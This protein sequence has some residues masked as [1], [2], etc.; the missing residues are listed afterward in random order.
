MSHVTPTVGI[1]VSSTTHTLFTATGTSILWDVSKVT[2][3]KLARDETGVLVKDTTELAFDGEEIEDI[4]TFDDDVFLLTRKPTGDEWSRPWKRRRNVAV[5]QDPYYEWNRPVFLFTVRAFSVSGG[6]QRGP[7]LQIPDTGVRGDLRAGPHRVMVKV[8]GQR[9]I[10]GIWSLPTLN[11]PEWGLLYSEL[12]WVCFPHRLNF[13][14]RRGLNTVQDPNT[15]AQEMGFRDAHDELDHLATRSD[16]SDEAELDTDESYPP[17]PRDEYKDEET[18]DYAFLSDT[19]VVRLRDIASDGYELEVQLQVFRIPSVPS[20]DVAP[21]PPNLLWLGVWSMERHFTLSDSFLR[22]DPTFRE[23][24]ALTVCIHNDDHCIQLVDANRLRD[25]AENPPSGEM[26][27]IYTVAF[28][29][30]EPKPDTPFVCATGR[31]V[32]PSTSHG[33]LLFPA[34]DLDPT[35]PFPSTPLLRFRPFATPAPA[36]DIPITSLI[37]VDELIVDF[38]TQSFQLG[39]GDPPFVVA[40][41]GRETLC[42]VF[43]ST[44]L[45]L[46]TQ[47]VDGAP[48]VWY[49]RLSPE[50]LSKIGV[51]GN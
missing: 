49:V 7:A 9:C 41:D 35:S 11:T 23:Q 16:K 8:I 29:D 50:L 25:L 3:V 22:V 36:V 30:G 28:D 17:A 34:C 20:Q 32:V 39:L 14:S 33:T 44:L 18:Q 4:A 2:L 38:R 27:S 43:R 21:T 6:V 46:E 1:D 15:I 26:V 47:G 45:P 13:Y 42:V 24:R 51:G 48:R 37:A 10:A 12:T 19:L 31:Y 5:N 40:W